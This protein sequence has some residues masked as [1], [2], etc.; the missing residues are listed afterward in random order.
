MAPLSVTV[1]EPVLVKEPTPKPSLMTPE[2][3]APVVLLPVVKAVPVA[4]FNTRLPLP[5]RL[6]MLAVAPLTFSSPLI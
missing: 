4:L 6:P 1:V 2:K 5:V 3:V